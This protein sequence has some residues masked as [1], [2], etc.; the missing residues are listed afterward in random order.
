MTP[1]ADDKR[2]PPA[3]H[4][5]ASTDNGIVPSRGIRDELV[6]F[7]REDIGYVLAV[8]PAIPEN[9]PYGIRE[10]IARRRIAAVTGR[11]PCGAQV[12][13][14]AEVLRGG[15]RTVEVEHERLCPAVTAHLAKAIRRWRR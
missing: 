10:G 15:A 1:V 14:N 8:L 5:G 9:A 4:Q 12:D 7:H 3:N 2:N 6:T 11:C 13:Y